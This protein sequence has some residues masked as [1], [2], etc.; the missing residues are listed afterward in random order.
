LAGEYF[1]ENKLF[2]SLQARETENMILTAAEKAGNKTRY[3]TVLRRLF[4]QNGSEE[5]YLRLK[6]LSGSGWPK[7]RASLLGKFQASGQIAILAPLLAADGDLDALTTV[8]KQGSLTLLQE[9]QAA[10]LPTHTAF[11]RNFYINSLSSYL[12]EHFGRQAAGEVRSQLA[13]LLRINQTA[14]VKEIIIALVA[15]FPDRES[16]PEEL[17]ELFPK[18]KGRFAVPPT[19]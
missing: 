1:L 10:L 15:R 11:V 18:S 7:E 2:N 17:A 8:L 12:T 3:K 5:I 6:T 14:L 19:S 13:E 16:L 9:Y 4:Q